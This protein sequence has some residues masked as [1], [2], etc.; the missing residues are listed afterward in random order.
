M[1]PWLSPLSAK[2]DPVAYRR[3]RSAFDKG[4]QRRFAIAVL[5]RMRS[6]SVI[7]LHPRVNVGLQ[8]IERV[9]QLASECAG[10]ELV[11]DG[12]VEAFANPVGLR[13]LCSRAGVL[14]VLQVQVQRV[15]VR[16]PVATIL[17]PPI[18]QYP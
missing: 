11:L 1:L 16:F 3:Q 10:V 17:T 18:G 8:L 6:L 14:D 12:L 2:F 13:A 9:I 5:T 7:A 4:L 15:F